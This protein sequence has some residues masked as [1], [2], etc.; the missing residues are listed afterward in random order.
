MNSQTDELVSRS[1][2]KTASLPSFAAK[3][4]KSTVINSYLQKSVNLSDHENHHFYRKKSVANKWGKTRA[5]TVCKSLSP[6]YRYDNCN[7]N[8]NGNQ[9][10]SGK[11]C[12][13]KKSFQSLDRSTYQCL[14]CAF[15]C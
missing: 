13:H 14:V 2:L 11:F 8:F 7:F 6:E 15:K 12:V 5:F 9:M 3:R 4:L 1:D 10:C